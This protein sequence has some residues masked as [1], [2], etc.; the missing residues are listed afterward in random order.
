MK[1]NVFNTVKIRKQIN[2]IKEYTINS[3]LLIN[4]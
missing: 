3:D 1:T 2:F 4:V